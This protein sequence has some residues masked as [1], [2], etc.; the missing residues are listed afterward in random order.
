AVPDDPLVGD[1]EPDVIRLDVDL[2][3]VRLVQEGAD[4]E[5]PGLVELDLLAQVGQRDAGVE[6]V[7]HD[8]QVGPLD[9]ERGGKAQRGGEDNL[10]Q[11]VRP[12]GGHALHEADL[13]GQADVP[14]QVGQ[15]NERPLQ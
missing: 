6:D 1:L 14:R 11:G 12:T 3:A 8:E 9:A 5:R 15:E 4:P 10:G 2:A 13:H 7:F